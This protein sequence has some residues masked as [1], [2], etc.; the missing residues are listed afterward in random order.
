MPPEFFDFIDPT[1]AQQ[2]VVLVVSIT[3]NH[4]RTAGAR[5]T[6]SFTP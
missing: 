2:I 6:D 1:F 4:F 5:R 3:N